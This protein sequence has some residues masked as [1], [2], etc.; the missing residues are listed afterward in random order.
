[1]KLICK[2][3][4]RMPNGEKHMEFTKDNT[5]EALKIDEETYI[6][7]DDNGEDVEFWNLGLMFIEA[8]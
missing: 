5:Y 3:E 6:V 2:N 4:A 7:E 1:M 8:E